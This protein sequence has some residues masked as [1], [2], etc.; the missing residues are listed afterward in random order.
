M[1]AIL[2]T[3]CPERARKIP[4]WTLPTSVTR[5]AATFDPSIRAVI[6][7]LDVR[8]LPQSYNVTAMTGITF[9]P[10]AESVGDAGRSLIALG[11][12]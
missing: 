3:A 7:D 11:V 4:K 12:A 1:S 8:P 9:R 2:R 10:A 6:P 5:L